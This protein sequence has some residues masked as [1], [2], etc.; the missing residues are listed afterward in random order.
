MTAIVASPE[1]SPR[2][3]E[4][5]EES[6]RRKRLSDK[7]FRLAN[8]RRRQVRAEAKRWLQLR[9]HSLLPLWKRLLVDPDD[10]PVEPRLLDAVANN[11]T[12][13]DARWLMHVDD[14]KFNERLANQAAH[15]AQMEMFDEMLR[16]AS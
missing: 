15:Q 6:R 14:Q 10:L 4:L 1:T 16:R 13:I 8:E 3:E 11:W 7:Y 9:E 2:I 5:K 12:T